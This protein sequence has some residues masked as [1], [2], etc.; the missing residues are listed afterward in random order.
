MPVGLQHAVEDVFVGAKGRPVFELGVPTMLGAF[1]VCQFLHSGWALAVGVDDDGAR[2]G[3]D[4]A[5][6][7]AG[8]EDAGGNQVTH[9]ASV[10][11]K[12]IPVVDDD[13][14]QASR[15]YDKGRALD[16]LQNSL[17]AAQ[18]AG[19]GAAMLKLIEE[20]P[21]LGMARAHDQVQREIAKLNKA[22]VNTVGDR[23]TIQA[24]DKARV[25]AMRGLNDAIKAMEEAE[26]KVTPGQRLRAAV[27][28]K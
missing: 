5:G 20:N 22:A 17:K 9:G 4:D 3:A 23:D 19:D 6:S 28:G 16:K 26:G 13:Q 24:I 10:F 12:C 15:Y 21:E 11:A 1:S 27:A 7:A 8:Q 25:D 18:A 14:V 2:A